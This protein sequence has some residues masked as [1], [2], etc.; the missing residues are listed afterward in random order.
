MNLKNFQIRLQ[1]AIDNSTTTLEYLLLAKA[2][3]AAQVGQV[4]SVTTFSNL[5]AAASNTGLLVFVTLEERLYWSTGSEWVLITQNPPSSLLWGWGSGFLGALG[6]NDS[7]G[8]SSPVSVVG[9]FTDWCQVG[10]GYNH[11]LAVRKNGTAWAWGLN[12]YGQLSD[13][14]TVSK[15]SPV[16]VVGGFTDWRQV[17][18]GNRHSVGIRTNGTAWAWGC[19]NTGALGTG[20]SSNRSSPTSVV[21]GFTDWCQIQAGA[22]HSGGLRSNCTI[23]M[24]GANN[25]GQLGNN[26]VLNNRSS[27]V[28]I[29]GGFTDWCYISM[30]GGEF[31]LAIRTNGTMWGWGLNTSAQLGDNSTT[32][33][34]SPV[35]VAGGFTDWCQVAA[36]VTHSIALRTNGTA[37]AWGTSS[38]GRLGDNGST[39]TPRSSPVSVSGGFTD[40]CQVGAGSAHSAG[41]R[42][43]G[44]LWTWGCNGQ[45]ALATNNAVDRSSPVSIV[46]G[47]TD[48]SLVTSNGA[49]V[50]AIRKTTT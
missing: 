48:W 33:R 40:W 20:N 32:N 17:A 50:F 3:Q 46:G 31:T 37:W 28:S 12:N 16:S 4:R 10:A 44:T 47:F 23:W 5:P 13:G 8:R 27:P 39:T 7:S 26:D 29:V 18:G 36:G 6:N 38:Y 21:G 11:T 9:G 19:G 15:S 22:S 34:A 45:G 49:N 41:V 1:E 43:N 24:W 14:T 30:G 2:L 35:S 42:T 25:F